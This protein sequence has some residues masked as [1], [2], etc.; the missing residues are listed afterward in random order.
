[1]AG[2]THRIANILRSSAITSLLCCVS[3]GTTYAEDLHAP[4]P[5][6]HA[7]P[8]G[9]GAYGWFPYHAS[10]AH[11][12]VLRG[13][14]AWITSRSQAELLH[15]EALRSREAAIEHALDNSV[16]R[17]ETRQTRQLMGLQHRETLR[18]MEQARRTQSAAEPSHAEPLDSVAQAER[19][20]E[21]KL[22]LAKQLLAQGRPDAAQRWF[23]EIVT[24]YPETAAAKDAQLLLAEK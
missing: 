10:T 16:R 12:G 14:G 9:A 3:A 18:R 13:R 15:Y 23:H 2:S 20:A 6:V 19:H 7:V 4:R 1:M 24:T 21:S 5:H 8:F 11:E 22:N 17:L